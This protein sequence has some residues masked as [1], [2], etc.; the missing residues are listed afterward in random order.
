MQ[1]PL[2]SRLSAPA[3]GDEARGSHR[4]NHIGAQ[5]RKVHPSALLLWEHTR[6]IPDLCLEQSC[7]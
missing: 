3:K 1:Q 7:A 4:Q 5:Y 6:E 2:F